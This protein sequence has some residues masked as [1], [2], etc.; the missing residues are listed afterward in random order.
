MT[1]SIKRSIRTKI[2]VLVSIT[3]VGLLTLLFFISTE[4]YSDSFNKLAKNE[5]LEWVGM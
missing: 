1:P 4:V 3:M 5:S 2:M